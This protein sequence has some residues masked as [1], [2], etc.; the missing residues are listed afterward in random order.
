MPDIFEMDLD[1][2]QLLVA[3]VGPGL[4]KEGLGALWESLERLHASGYVVCSSCSKAV[5]KDERGDVLD[6]S[7]RCDECRP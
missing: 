3:P 6:A 7:G 1:G 5:E 4:T 2:E